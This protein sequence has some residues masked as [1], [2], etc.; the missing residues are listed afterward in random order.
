LLHKSLEGKISIRNHHNYYEKHSLAMPQRFFRPLSWISTAPP[1]LA[2]QQVWQQ[3]PL[4]PLLQR[5][6]F[7]SVS[8]QLPKAAFA[9]LL[10]HPPP[11]P[12]SPAKS[13]PSHQALQVIQPFSR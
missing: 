1:F 5:L 12:E 3:P 11:P 13:S 2:V 4:L 7:S 9:L 6:S 10:P 8:K